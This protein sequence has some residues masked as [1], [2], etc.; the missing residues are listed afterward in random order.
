MVN[1]DLETSQEREVVEGGS[2]K[3]KLY[4]FS[5]IRDQGWKGAE[6]SVPTV[7]L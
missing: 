1:Q 7:S 5:I 3:S 6:K 4:A 2:V